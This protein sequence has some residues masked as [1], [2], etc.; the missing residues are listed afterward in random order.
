[1]EQEKATADGEKE[2]T[3]FDYV[4]RYPLCFEKSGQFRKSSSTPRDQ[5]SGKPCPESDSAWPTLHERGVGQTIPSA[6]WGLAGGW[7]GTKPKSVV[8]ATVKTAIV[9]IDE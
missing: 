2:A 7:G 4:R 3:R 8:L 1:M 6:V 5:T 9:K